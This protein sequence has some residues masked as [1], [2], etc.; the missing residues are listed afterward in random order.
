MSNVNLPPMEKLYQEE[1][2]ESERAIKEIDALF[3]RTGKLPSSC[4][5]MSNGWRMIDCGSFDEF[6]ECSMPIYCEIA[7]QCKEQGITHV[8]DI[9]CCTAWQG[10]IFAAAGIDYTGI[11]VDPHDK[12]L[13]PKQDG[14]RMVNRA[15]PFSIETKDRAH[16]A[17][18]SNLCVGYSLLEGNPTK[19]Q[20]FTRKMYEQ[21][22]KDFDY[23]IGSVGPDERSYFQSR[24][25]ILEKDREGRCTVWGNRQRFNEF[26]DEK[27]R[28][29]VMN[30]TSS[31]EEELLA[32][33]DKNAEIQQNVKNELQG[34]ANRFRSYGIDISYATAD[35]VPYPDVM[36]KDRESGETA[37]VW[38]VKGKEDF[39]RK[40][41]KAVTILKEH[42]VQQQEDFALADM[43]AYEYARETK[44]RLAKAFREI[45][46]PDRESLFVFSVEAGV[47]SPALAKYT[48]DALLGKDSKQALDVKLDIYESFIDNEKFEF[49]NRWESVGQKDAPISLDN[50]SVQAFQNQFTGEQVSFIMKNEKDGTASMTVAGKI[51][52]GTAQELDDYLKYGM[53]KIG[54]SMDN[55]KEK[56]GREAVPER[57]IRKSAGKL[58]VRFGKDDKNNG[59]DM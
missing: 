15:Y 34:Y 20:D 58:R 13:M 52:D 54:F 55:F 40:F 44:E 30:K 47:D 4:D 33:M 31:Y 49:G 38:D 1:F 9:G 6:I 8:Y 23:F 46:K 43:D 25:G 53:K 5:E 42:I 29:D 57:D 26:K 48:I 56:W 24:F 16:T 11:E 21:I 18:I 39:I 37:E 35:M 2:L 36:V 51:S 32:I 17:A 28:G 19:R 50:A 3:L 59:R 7:R 22:A 27:M 14:I 10:R 41:P 12:S 45:T